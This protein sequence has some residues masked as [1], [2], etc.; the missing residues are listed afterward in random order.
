MKKGLLINIILL[1]SVLL[2]SNDSNEITFY[3]VEPFVFEYDSI[4]IP[5]MG[6]AEIIMEQ[7]GTPEEVLSY[8]WGKKY[9]G[10]QE[11]SVRYDN[12]LWISFNSITNQIQSL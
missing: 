8:D 3:K 9:A 12:Y 4:E 5:L 1:S 11:L 7:L 6:N 2:F 10:I